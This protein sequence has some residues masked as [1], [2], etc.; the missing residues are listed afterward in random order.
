MKQ[1]PGISISDLAQTIGIST[2]AIDKNITKLK[3]GKLITR[4]GT[5]KS[6]YWEVL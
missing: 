6:G 3:K 1:N 5:T 2:R 4:K